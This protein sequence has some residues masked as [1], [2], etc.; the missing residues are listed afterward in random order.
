MPH[1]SYL[2]G[3]YYFYQK[4]LMACIDIVE[5]DRRM[6]RGEGEARQKVKQEVYLA[7]TFREDLLKMLKEKLV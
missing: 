7:T 1:Y 2:V 6:R 5:V 3:D 4:E